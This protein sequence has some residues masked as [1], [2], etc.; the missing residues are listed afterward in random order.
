MTMIAT[1]DF[2]TKASSAISVAAKEQTNGGGICLQANLF[3]VQL[4]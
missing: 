1:D 2:E 4:I 3:C